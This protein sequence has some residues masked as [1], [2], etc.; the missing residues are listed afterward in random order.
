MNAYPRYAVLWDMDGVLV[1]SGELHRRAWRVFL[2]RRGVPNDDRIH[3]LGFGRPNDQVLPDFFGHD[4]SGEQI[5]RLSDE[6]EACYRE[7]VAQE[8]IAS[9]PGVLSWM[10]RFDE[11]GVH[12]ALATSGCRANAEFILDLTGARRYMQAVVAAEDVHQGK[13]HPDLFLEAAERVGVPPTRCLVVEDSLH[14]I[15][16]AQA[17]AMRCLA[18]TTTHSEQELEGCDL[19]LAS[20]ESFS[21][22]AWRRLFGAGET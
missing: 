1:D 15:R 12:Q 4:L 16:A 3:V 13:P 5:Q 14:G 21:W 20:M 18:L 2:A 11:A 8:G 9:P 17:A 22:H 6:K 7:I 19:V 10:A